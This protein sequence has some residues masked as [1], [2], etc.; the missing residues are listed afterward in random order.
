MPVF[1]VR[2]K[3]TF[4]PPQFISLT[5]PEKYKVHLHI[6]DLLICFPFHLYL[7]CALFCFLHFG[8]LVGSKLCNVQVSQQSHLFTMF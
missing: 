6:R 2:I 3:V 4:F 1:Q 5:C 7:K 8:L